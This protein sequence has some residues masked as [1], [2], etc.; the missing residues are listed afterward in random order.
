MPTKRIATLSGPAVK[1]FQSWVSLPRTAQI[2]A[3]QRSK[4]GETSHRFQRLGR[5]GPVYFGVKYSGLG[6]NTTSSNSLQCPA[7]LHMESFPEFICVTPPNREAGPGLPRGEAWI[8]HHAHAPFSAQP[9]TRRIFTLQYIPPSPWSMACLS[10][11]PLTALLAPSKKFAIKPTTVR[12]SPSSQ[13][14]YPKPRGEE[15]T[16]HSEPRICCSNSGS[17]SSDNAAAGESHFC[18]S[19]ICSCSVDAYHSS[20]PCKCSLPT[21]ALIDY[22][23]SIPNPPSH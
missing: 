12:P 22:R 5:P 6:V 20:H 8:P 19:C 17:P 1:Y 21:P 14:S 18:W 9:P 3:A 7:P 4:I 10:V 2:Y 13:S 15:D 16:H 11:M 23:F